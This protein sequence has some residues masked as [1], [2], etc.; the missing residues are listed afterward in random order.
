M[1]ELNTCSSVAVRRSTWRLWPLA[2]G[3]GLSSNSQL[4]EFTR[5][6]EW[7]AKNFGV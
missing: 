2:V 5:H 1:H 7:W 4:S 3:R 6:G